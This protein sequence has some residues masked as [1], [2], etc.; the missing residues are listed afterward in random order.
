MLLQA[1]EFHLRIYLTNNILSLLFTLYKKTTCKK[2]AY[3]N[4]LK[5]PKRVW[6]EVC[7]DIKE[8]TSTKFINL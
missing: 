4:P 1:W 6:Y 8:K 5:K 7:F 2:Y 3:Q